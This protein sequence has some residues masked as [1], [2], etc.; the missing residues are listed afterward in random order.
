CEERFAVGKAADRLPLPFPLPDD[1]TEVRA[2][3]AGVVAALRAAAHDVCLL[4]PVDC[5]RV[6][7]RLLGEIADAC[8][9]DVDVAVPQPGPLPGAYRRRALDTLDRR[10][11][12]GRLTL[13]DSL[14]P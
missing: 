12:A 2:P 14:D 10:L 5:P 8:T 6:S 11:H 9:D 13:R 4:L 7:A 1:G 3:I